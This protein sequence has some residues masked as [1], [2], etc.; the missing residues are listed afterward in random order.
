MLFE[1]WHLKRQYDGAGG[2]TDVSMSVP[3][4]AVY[5]LCGA[6]GSGKTT[7]LSVL[8]GLMYAESGRLTLSGNSIP[9][10]RWARRD[11]FGFVADEPVLDDALTPWQWLEF[12]ASLKRVQPAD[13]AESDARMLTLMPDALHQPI[14]TLSGGTRRKVAL[15]TEFVTASAAVVLDEPLAGLDPLAIHGFHQLVRRYVTTGRAVVLSTH[16]LHEAEAIAT[17]VG[18]LAGGVTRLEGPVADV[19]GD[20]SLLATFLT[21]AAN[22]AASA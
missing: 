20:R 2:V 3:N 10:D 1:L 7:T 15:W 17:H 14:Y 9:L 11:G 5:A 8:A 16:L 12:V 22:R 13:A 4:G 21:V 18:V 6:N 19:C